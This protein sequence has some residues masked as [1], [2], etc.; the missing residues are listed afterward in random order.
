MAF[1]GSG[2]YVLPGAALADGQ[3][4]SATE[5]N[6]FRDDVATALSTCVTRDGQSPATANLPMGGFKHTSVAVGS[7]LTDYSRYDQ[8]QN[9]SA[10]WLTSVTGVDTITASAP[11]APAAYAA[12]QTF[13]FVAAGANTGAV[14][15]NVSSLGAKSVTKNGTTALAAGNIPS[16]SVVQVI[17]DGTQFQLTNI[18]ISGANTDIT[19]M[20]AVT[21][22]STA[23]GVSVHGTNTNNDAAAGYVGEIISS[24][25]AIGSPVALTTSTAANVTSISLTAGHWEVDGYVGIVS[26][27]AG[28]TIT[29]EYGGINTTSATLPTTAF[30]NLHQ[31]VGPG[32]GNASFVGHLSS[33]TIKIAGL[34]TVYLVAQSSFAVSTA[35]AFGTIK[36]IRI[37]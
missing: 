28:T 17:Y 1:N 20:S 24:T 7:S 15:L 27:N 6:T 35:A 25:V 10:Q 8:M 36:A 19:S 23:A 30:Q 22:L 32:A 33:T 2:T 13:K 21:T 12:G 11:V 29:A 3:T 26:T 9:S 16:G 31:A 14:T 18:Y 34:T 4:V 5:H 37:R